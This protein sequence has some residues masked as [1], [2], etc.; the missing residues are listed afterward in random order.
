MEKKEDNE[1]KVSQMEEDKLEKEKTGE[2][3]KNKSEEDAESSEEE[4][5]KIST[6]G[7]FTPTYKMSR[8]TDSLVG[9]LEFSPIARQR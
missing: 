2:K 5:S 1:Q 7:D 8:G 6:P 3:S 9:R 4:G